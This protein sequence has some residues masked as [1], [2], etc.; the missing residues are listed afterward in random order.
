M[1]ALQRIYKA[2]KEPVGV[3]HGDGPQARRVCP[4]MHGLQGHQPC[5]T[6]SPFLHAKSRGGTRECR[7][8]ML[9]LKDRPHEGILSGPMSQKDIPKTVFTCHKGRFEF[10][11]MPFGVKNA[12]SVFQELMQSIFKEDSHYC[13]PYMDDLI[14]FSPCWGDHV[15]HVRIVLDKLRKAGL[16]VNPAKCK[17]GGSKMEFLGHLVGEGSM[18]V[19]DHR[20]EALATYNRPTTKKGLRAFLGAVGF[21][22]RATSSC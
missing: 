2:F 13:T 11:R 8:G 20:A 9:Y 1:A 18:S 15:K 3:T 4:A 21:Y 7:Q 12:P 17:W 19:P 10:L 22:R 16:T 5:N 14:I 6:S